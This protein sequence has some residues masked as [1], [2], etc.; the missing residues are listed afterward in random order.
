MPAV[1]TYKPASNQIRRRVPEI[2]LNVLGS[3]IV[4]KSHTKPYDTPP[5]MRPGSKVPHNPDNPVSFFK[6]DK[7]RVIK[8]V[9]TE[10]DQG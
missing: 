8:S 4:D 9:V 5:K 6:E 7:W 3:H 1:G 2:K 10:A